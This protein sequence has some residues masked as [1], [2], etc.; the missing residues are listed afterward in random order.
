VVL[1]VNADRQIVRH[2]RADL[3]D[4][5]SAAAQRD[6]PMGAQAP[7]PDVGLAG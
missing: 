4:E 6:Y 2:A 3:G 7:K 5:W 1:I